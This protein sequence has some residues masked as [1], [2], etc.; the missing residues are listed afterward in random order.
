MTNLSTPA[1]P[2]A[3]HKMASESIPEF[4]FEEMNKLL[5]KKYRRTT[6]DAIIRLKDFKDALTARMA[7][8][9][10]ALEFDDRWLD[11]EEN[12]RDQGWDVAFD[13][14]GYNESYSSYYKF[15]AKR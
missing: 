13:S 2:E 10:S 6:M 12:Y 11:L 8:D 3:I 1:T 14:P 5:V 4:V 9:Q 7:S 15:E